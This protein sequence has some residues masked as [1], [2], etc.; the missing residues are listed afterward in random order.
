MNNNWGGARNGSG[1]KQIS[2]DKKTFGCTV[3]LTQSELNYI[4]SQSGRSRSEKLRKIINEHKN[5]K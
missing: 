4:D 5:L 2:E 3:Q 1:R